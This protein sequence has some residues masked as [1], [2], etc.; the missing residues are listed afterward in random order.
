LFVFNL[1]LCIVLQVSLSMRY[2]SVLA[3]DDFHCVCV[4][5]RTVNFQT[6]QTESKS[7]LACSGTISTDLALSNPASTL[8]SQTIDPYPVL[9]AYHS[10]PHNKR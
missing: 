7:D 4:W 5:Q 2:S 8:R 10:C 1:H 9:T 3:A 6:L